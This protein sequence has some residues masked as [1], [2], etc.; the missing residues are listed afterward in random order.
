MLLKEYLGQ[1]THTHITQ[2]HYLSSMI[3]RKQA[4]KS[5]EVLMSL[6]EGLEA[7]S[8]WECCS[9]LWRPVSLTLPVLHSFLSPRPTSEHPLRRII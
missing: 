8:S 4:R 6:M 9:P 1:L 5:L 2:A 7:V 3:V